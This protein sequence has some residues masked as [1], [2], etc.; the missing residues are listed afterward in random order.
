[1]ADYFD[2]VG[3]ST[4]DTKLSAIDIVQ[5][6]V[7]SNENISRY[8]GRPQQAE[9]V[10]T[11][12]SRFVYTDTDRCSPKATALALGMLKA[13]GRQIDDCEALASTQAIEG[14]LRVATDMQGVANE[15]GA[16][17]A[18]TINTSLEPDSQIASEEAL[19]CVANAML[20]RPECKKHFFVAHGFDSMAKILGMPSLS[21]TTAFL[22]GRCLFMAL[23]ISDSARYCIDNL[24]LQ[25]E[26][27]RVASVYLD[28]MKSQTDENGGRF[29]SQQ[30]LAEILK[31]AMSLCVWYHRSINTPQDG[32]LNSALSSES[33]E[34][35]AG[36]LKVSLE[37]LNVL[38]A[39][40]GHIQG[41]MPDAY[42]QAIGIIVN[43]PI[44]EPA[45]IRD[46]WR[47]KSQNSNGG[48][49]VN[50]KFLFNIFERLVHFTVHALNQVTSYASDRSD[51][52]KFEAETAPITLVLARLVAENTDMRESVS[53]K[54]Y[55]PELKSE[56]NKL[57]EDRQGVA[58]NLVRLLR[59][60]QGGMLSAAAGEFLMALHGH[61]VRQFIK[62]VGYGNAAG[63]LVARGIE[64][65][66]DIM[67]QDGQDADAS[68]PIDPVTG[69]AFSQKDIDRELASMTEEEKEREAERLFV[70]FERLNKTGVIKVENPIR[71]AVES[72]RFEEIS[73]SS[74]SSDS[75]G[76]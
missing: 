21:S 60:P 31:S 59:I 23:N 18:S 24:E 3:K 13:F 47:P 26:L 38:H 6:L 37:T 20:L 67:E 61:D 40:S 11:L 70:L 73:D 74:D 5:G 19:T 36:L 75:D 58:G 65:P 8:M 63:Y 42:Q 69:R 4:P 14:L 71:A 33:A 51:F 76:H 45:A 30:V 55:P 28:R 72:G 9:C 7:K 34:K 66:A 12:L 57:P 16:K 41:H 64:I 53:A 48:E 44:N 39:Q 15:H 43:F 32:D 25:N 52:T 10:D 54:V 27:A 68:I 35:L 46:I 50:I 17:V 56:L 62:A 49:L 29:S 1:M 2:L 22:C